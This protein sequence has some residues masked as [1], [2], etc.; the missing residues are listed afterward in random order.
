MS[1]DRDDGGPVTK[2]AAYD[3]HIAP[4]MTQII[5]L[6]HENKINMAATF[7]LGFDDDGEAL[8]CTTVLPVDPTDVEGFRRIEDCRAV[9][10]QRP[11]FMAFTITEAK[12][13]DK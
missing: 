9:M 12:A 2:E 3:E 13:G 10:Y 6:C 4:L 8:A 1:G 5:A 11:S 7:S